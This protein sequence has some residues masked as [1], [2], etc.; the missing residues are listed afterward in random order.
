MHYRTLA[1]LLLLSLSVKKGAA[2]NFYPAAVIP[3]VSL[4]YIFGSGVSFGAEINYTPFAFRTGTGKTATGLYA[5][6]NYF[7]SKGEMYRESWYHTFSAGALGF[8][9]DRF[10]YKLGISKSVLR[11]GRNHMNKTKSR[12]LT[13]DFDVSY[14]PTQNGEFIGYRFYP[15]GNACFGMDIKY[16]HMVYG[17]Y[18][19]NCDRKMFAADAE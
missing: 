11:W 12:S 13:P 10:M 14:S 9:D 19:F 7:Y 3:G 5:S 1:V 17:A 2:R 18:R 16:V 8:T 4:G 15:P 6:F